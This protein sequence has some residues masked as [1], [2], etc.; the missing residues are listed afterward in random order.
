MHDYTA[1][2]LSIGG[3]PRA[4]LGEFSARPEHKDEV[5]AQ[6]YRRSGLLVVETGSRE[7]RSLER[8]LGLLRREV[9]A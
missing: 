9:R 1:Y 3:H 7:A 8:Q 5:A 6:L 2:R 4:R